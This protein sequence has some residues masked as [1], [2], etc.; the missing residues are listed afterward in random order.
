VE[1]PILPLLV[2][3]PEVRL[4]HQAPLILVIAVGE[5]EEQAA[6]AVSEVGKHLIF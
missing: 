1:E 6:A 5:A 4:T 3:L 2:P